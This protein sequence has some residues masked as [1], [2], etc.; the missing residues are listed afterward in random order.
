MRELRATGHLGNLARHITA[1]FLVNDLELWPAWCVS[2]GRAKQSQAR[3]GDEVRS[4]EYFT[5][6]T[7]YV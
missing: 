1:G 2:P 4:V 5:C 7:L 3:V 6:D